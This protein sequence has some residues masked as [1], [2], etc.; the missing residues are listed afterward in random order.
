MK[1]ETESTLGKVEQ[2]TA[3]AGECGA[4]Q[5]LRKRLD[6]LASALIAWQ[7][8]RYYFS[9][10]WVVDWDDPE[11]VSVVREYDTVAA[12]L[13]VAPC[14]KRG[15]VEFDGARAE[16]LG[17]RAFSRMVAEEVGSGVEG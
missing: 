13:G 17:E 6:D 9:E 12:A 16:M 7:W 5:E 15:R 8:E 11:I 2:S 1:N 14:G 3:T 4:K 10:D